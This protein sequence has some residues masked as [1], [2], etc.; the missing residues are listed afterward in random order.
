MNHKEL[1][2]RVHV[3]MAPYQLATWKSHR[4]G[5]EFCKLLSAIIAIIIVAIIVVTL[6]K[7]DEPM[8]EAPKNKTTDNTVEPNDSDDDDQF[9]PHVY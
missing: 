1:L 6:Y 9:V 3:L 5:M 4:L 8:R 7:K 2:Q